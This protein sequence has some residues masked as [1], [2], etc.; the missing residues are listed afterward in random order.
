MLYCTEDALSWSSVVR[1]GLHSA[2]RA[3]GRHARKLFAG[4]RRLVGRGPAG[5]GPL[6]PLGPMQ[7]DQSIR[8]QTSFSQR[9]ACLAS[10]W[11]YYMTRRPTLSGPA[12][13]SVGAESQRTSASRPHPPPLTVDQLIVGKTK[14]VGAHQR[15][16]P[17]FGR[18]A[19]LKAQINPS[20]RM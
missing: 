4:A 16:K 14:E 11:G 2:S 15:R 12:T 6:G 10:I 17:L 1:H 7:G 3:Q 20:A 5:L 8:D 19:G 13:G 18:G 9:V